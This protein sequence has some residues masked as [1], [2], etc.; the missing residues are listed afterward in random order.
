[1]VTDLSEDKLTFHNAVAKENI[2]VEKEGEE[3]DDSVIVGLR[4]VGPE[5]S[6]SLTSDTKYNIYNGK[7]DSDGLELLS[8]V[9]SKQF[10]RYVKKE[11]KI[12]DHEMKDAPHYCEPTCFGLPF[13]IEVK[14]G[15]CQVVTKCYEV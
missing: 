12:R 6:V 1:M 13:L 3:P 8:R 11:L 2:Y 4:G 14:D 10:R 9:T 5:M 7:Y 15:K